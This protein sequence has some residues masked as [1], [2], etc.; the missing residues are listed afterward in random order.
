MPSLTRRSLLKN[1]ATGLAG[2]SF[3]SQSHCASSLLAA[4]QS[5]SEWQKPG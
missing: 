2:L 4:Q 5:F 1:S 3:T